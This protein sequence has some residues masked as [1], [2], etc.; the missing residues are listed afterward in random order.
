MSWAYG[1]APLSQAW[2]ISNSVDSTMT[3]FTVKTCGNY[4]LSPVMTS[5]NGYSPVSIVTDGS[6]T[7]TVGNPSSITLT[8][9]KMNGDFNVLLYATDTVGYTITGDPTRYYVTPLYFYVKV[10]IT[11]VPTGVP[12]CTPAF[13]QTSQPESPVNYTVYPV[14]STLTTTATI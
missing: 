1:S 14:S 6:L 3:N 9:P 12:T 7:S 8:S 11:G 13:T 5:I 10:V 2:T 4:L